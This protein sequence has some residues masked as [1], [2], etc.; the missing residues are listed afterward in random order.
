MSRWRDDACYEAD[1]ASQRQ[2]EKADSEDVHIDAGSQPARQPEDA[3]RSTGEATE[4]PREVQEITDRQPEVPIAEDGVPF[5]PSCR[6][7][8]WLCLSASQPL[9]GRVMVEY[10]YTSDI[11]GWQFR[12]M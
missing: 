8:M 10:R 2:E 11:F 9:I 1:A 12:Y 4:K 6:G 3:Q 7:L 5:M